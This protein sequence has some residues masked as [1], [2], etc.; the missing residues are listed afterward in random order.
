MASSG[1][2]EARQTHGEI[3]GAAAPERRLK[4]YSFWRSS[5]SYRVRIALSLKG[6]DYEYKPINLLANEQ[7]HP[8]F[9]KLN[10][11]K[12][13]P[14]LVDGDDT[15]V[16]DSFAILLYLEDT[17]PQHPLLPQ[18]PKMKALNIQIASIVG[19]SIQPFQNNSVLDFIEEKL[20]SQEKVNWIQYHLNRGFTALEK[21]L[22]GCTTTYATGDEIQL[23][24]LFLEPQIY[25]GIKRFGI[26]MTNYPTLARLHEAYMEH[27]AFQAA[28]PER[29]PDAPSS[30]E[31]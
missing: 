26:D 28:L 15:V 24:D 5:C 8:E 29:Q 30:P 20:D 3:A 23:G 1:S 27:P 11:M 12:Y 4:L 6:L 31:I 7:S 25:G 13:V 19:S 21:M 9:E 10:P 17:Y 14:A 2:P 22:K 18:D 16:V